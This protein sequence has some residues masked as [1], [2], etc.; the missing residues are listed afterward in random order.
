MS[1]LPTPT[2][3]VDGI[4]R[5]SLYVAARLTANDIATMVTS[6]HS[7]NL[8]TDPSIW[9]LE[10][11]SGGIHRILDCCRQEILVKGVEVPHYSV[12]DNNL[13]AYRDAILPFIEERMFGG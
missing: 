2:E 9:A 6:F 5:I 1:R 10:M 13:E 3:S 7:S 12:G 8:D 4:R 11:K